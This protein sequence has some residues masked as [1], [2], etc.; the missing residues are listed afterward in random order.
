MG[1]YVDITDTKY[2]AWLKRIAAIRFCYR[3]FVTVIFTIFIVTLTYGLAPYIKGTEEWE[4]M[5]FTLSQ[6]EAIMSL[7]FMCWLLKKMIRCAKW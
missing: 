5:P 6:L 3:L 1:E 2:T 4:N 7:L